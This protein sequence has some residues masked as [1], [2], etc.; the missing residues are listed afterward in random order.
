MIWQVVYRIDFLS[1]QHAVQTWV[2]ALQWSQEL[3]SVRPRPIL[4][5]V[6]WKRLL[7]GEPCRTDI[8]SGPFGAPA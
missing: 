8:E 6:A 7:F 5:G 3:L 4:A 2:E 1:D